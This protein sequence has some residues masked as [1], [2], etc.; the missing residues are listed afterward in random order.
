MTESSTPD[1]AAHRSGEKKVVLDEKPNSGEKLLTLPSIG[2]FGQAP[3]MPQPLYGTQAA[4]MAILSSPD[5]GP[6]QAGGAS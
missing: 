5:G 4:A 3:T 1:D 6:E 2:S